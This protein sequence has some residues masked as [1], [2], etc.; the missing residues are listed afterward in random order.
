M[1]KTLFII[2][3]LAI[4]SCTEINNTESIPEIFK[5]NFGK[6]RDKKLAFNFGDVVKFKNFDYK[7]IICDISVDEGGIW[8]GIV[9]IDSQNHL[10]SRNIPS[11]LSKECIKLLDFTYLNQSGINSVYK[12]ETIKLDFSKIGIGSSSP[13]KDEKELIRDYERGLEFRKQP[14]TPC[15]EKLKTLEPI[16]ENYR[17]LKEIEF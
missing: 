10:F 15:S 8:Y 7:G 14:E 2:L 12:I 17:D 13:V 16:N 1:K 5:T 6:F 4:L 3:L 11:G 9:F